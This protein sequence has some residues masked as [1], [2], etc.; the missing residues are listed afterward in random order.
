MIRCGIDLGTTYS[1]IS[2]YDEDSQRV[3]TID[4]AHADG[5]RIIP[6][7]VFYEPSGNV[8][9]G[10]TARNSALTYEDR[11]I[12]G[13]KRVM[14]H[15]FK[16]APIDGQEYTPQQVSAKILEVLKQ[17]AETHLMREV[18]EV[19]ITVP[20][21]FGDRERNATK[22]AGELAGLTVLELIPEPHAAALAYAIDNAHDV[23]DQ[24]LIVYD[25]GG[26][27]FDVTLIHTQRENAGDDIAA[28][29]I[30]T[31]AKNGNQ[32]LGGLDWDR[33]LADMVAD[34]A[35]D[36]YGIDDPRLDP[37][38][39]VALL[40][41]CEKAKRNLSQA[42]ATA[43]MADMQG[44]QVDISRTDFE[45]ASS[46]LLLGTERL[47]NNV[48]EDAEKNHGLLTE[49]RIQDLVAEGHDRDE[50][51]PR[52][53]QLL[54][55]GG[56]TRMPMVRDLVERVMGEPPLIYRN[57]DLMVTVGAAYRAYLTTAPRET[58][59]PGEPPSETPVLRTRHGGIKMI[60]P[61]Q[62]M[63]NAVGVEVVFTDRRGNVTG[64]QNVVLIEDKAPYGEVYEQIFQTAF[65]NMTEIPLVFYEGDSP[66]ID[67]CQWLADVCIIGIPHNRP[68][69]SE[70]KVSIGYDMNG[71][72]TGWA[73]DVESGQQIAI[74]I[75]RD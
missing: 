70:V 33:I 58:I 47:L 51:E 37:K 56:S 19:I 13:I 65:D 40:G 12:I 14:G 27:T 25:L 29:K 21:H 16:T 62:D 3:D 74:T 52:K 73:T 59:P 24:N 1:A 34:K 61:V 44:H 30:D 20:A 53:I 57:P 64:K 28:L 8:I 66:N 48:L 18:K 11:V 17:D 10:E 2:Y 42:N 60:E 72:I 45:D 9:V 23:E 68:A 35:M 75:T 26:G 7:V 22:E 43:V 49:N 36:Q 69:G 39:E 38:T 71:I 31:L 4:L 15:P 54:L 41:Y 5:Q 32:H 55:C 6:S 50:L 67:E 46:G 63:G